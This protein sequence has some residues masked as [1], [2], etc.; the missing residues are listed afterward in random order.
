MCLQK[1]KQEREA[2]VTLPGLQ[3]C[4][5]ERKWEAISRSRQAEA[6]EPGFVEVPPPPKY[7][8]PKASSHRVLLQNDRALF[9]SRVLTQEK[10]SMESYDIDQS[11]AGLGGRAVQPV[12]SNEEN[13]SNSTA[14]FSQG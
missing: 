10:T 4:H 3:A 14:V 12:E 1:I 6:K 8:Q 13:H 11:L 5:E 9:R 7:K 2:S